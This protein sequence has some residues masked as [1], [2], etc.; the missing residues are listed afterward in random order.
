MARHIFRPTRYHN[1]LGTAEPCLRVASGDVIVAE[2]VDA[3]GL[4]AHEKPVASRRSA[5]DSV[6]RDVGSIDATFAS[7][8]KTIRGTP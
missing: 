4:D 6:W 1:T 3:S 8:R 5:S 7:T 2:T